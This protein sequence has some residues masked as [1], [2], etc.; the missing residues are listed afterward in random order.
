[1]TVVSFIVRSLLLATAVFLLS[2]GF[3]Y[4]WGPDIKKFSVKKPTKDTVTIAGLNALL[5]WGFFLIIFI[6]ALLVKAGFWNNVN[7]LGGK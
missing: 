7:V 1:M 2:P 4:S 6:F 5:V 3:L